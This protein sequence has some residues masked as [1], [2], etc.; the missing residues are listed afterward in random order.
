MLPGE[1]AFHAAAVVFLG[2]MILAA[3]AVLVVA[4][5]QR[6]ALVRLHHNIS[7]AQ[8]GKL[9]PLD[10]QRPVPGYL[11]RVMQ[12][13]NAMVGVLRTIFGTVEECQNR[14]IKERNQ[15]NALLQ[16]LPGALLNVDD[17]LTLQSVNR[18]ATETFGLD[19]ESLVGKNLFDVIEVREP[20]RELLR[21]AFL[22][23]RQLKNQEIAIRVADQERWFT[24][25]LSFL[26][27]RD[28]DLGAVIIFQ[29]ITSYKQLQETIAQREKLVGMGKVAAGVAHELNT[30]LGNIVGYSQLLTGNNPPAARQREYAEIIAEEARRCSQIVSDLLNFGRREQCDGA[31]CEL[32]AMVQEV[33]DSFIK[34]RLKRMRIELSMDL[35]DRKLVAEGACGELEIVLT[36]LLLNATQ[37]L[38]G[39]EAPEIRVETYGSA[40]GAVN[41]SVSDNGPG[42]SEEQRQRIFEP[43]YTTKEVGAGS[44]LGLA[45]S[46]A[47]LSRRG[48]SIDLDPTYQ[49]GARFVVR[50]PGSTEEEEGGDAG[51]VGG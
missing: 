7:D 12:D 37:E 22:Y 18:L 24:L 47:L 9:E 27:E 41:L 39:T 10:T 42:V 5:V 17:N 35:A 46:Q 49:D 2:L 33:V 30:P 44:G 43:F 20:G 34:C 25:N 14:V 26:S 38:A 36:N 23:K 32:N 11:G 1:G 28:A 13:Y 4:V 15:V 51:R 6:R 21:D 29:D 19:A 45:I 8:E 48:G 31:T 40:S 3:L 16:S 50:L